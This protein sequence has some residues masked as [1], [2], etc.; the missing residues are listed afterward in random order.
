MGRVELGVG[1]GS[2]IL[3]GLTDRSGPRVD[4]KRRH[5]PR[6]PPAPTAP[7]RRVRSEQDAQA[8]RSNERPG[9]VMTGFRFDAR[10]PLFICG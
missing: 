6:L 5:A 4:H 3:V 9:G 1:G 10:E 7:G 2:A 8:T